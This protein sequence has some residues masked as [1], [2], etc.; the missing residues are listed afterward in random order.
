MTRWPRNSLADSSRRVMLEELKI[1][2][3]A[4]IAEAHIEFGPGLTVLTGETGAGKTVL[5]SALKLLM[6]ERADSGMIRAGANQAKISGRF[7]FED[8][9]GKDLTSAGE[10]IIASRTITDNGRN[11]CELNGEMAT[12]SNLA[13]ALGE[14]ID[15]H[16]QHDHQMLLRPTTHVGLLDTFSGDDI[17]EPKENYRIARDEYRKALARLKTLQEEVLTNEHELEMNRLM[18]AEIE[19]ID[20]KPHEDEEISDKLPALRHAEEIAQALKEAHEGLGGESGALNGLFQVIR[21]LESVTAYR[22]D[23]IPL[24]ERI[25]AAKIDL[26]D[27]SEEVASLSSTME[28]DDTKLDALI[29]RLSDLDSLK[30]RFGPS[31]DYV[32]QRRV[33]LA[34]VLETVE[35]SDEILREARKLVEAAQ[36]TLENSAAALHAIRS[37]SAESFV[38]RLR[39]SV[40]DLALEQARFEVQFAPLEFE[41]WTEQG[42]HQAEILYSSSAASPTRPLAKIASGGE[43]SRVMLALKS[44][45]GKGS[46]PEILVFD[47]ID[48]GIGGATAT[49]VGMRLADLA[50]TH[51]VIVVT[52]LAQVAV[53]G[54]RHFIVKRNSDELTD[55]TS[56]LEVS[57]DERISEIARLLSGETTNTARTHA[58]ELLQSADDRK[59]QRASAC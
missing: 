29:G 1:Q 28:F 18:L 51:Q 55:D 9:E 52:H 13:T 21:A 17:I 54:D 49:A 23:L 50:R 26:A 25:N 45:L 47:E 22:S 40:R 42:S 58:I 7:F 57:G 16:G 56:V 15:L 32:I 34:S 20:P 6:G 12:V 59:S 48:A 31:L 46:A 53:F 33:T 11:K 2:D 39:E 44:V 38:T 37:S 10:E 24:L 35:H 30:K 19:R 43:I 27:V 36:S 3:V 14:H 4:L 41:R 5:L 8:K